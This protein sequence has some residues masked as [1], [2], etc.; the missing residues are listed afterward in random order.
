[1]VDGA[2]KVL[3]DKTAY[4]LGPIYGKIVGI[5]ILDVSGH[6]V[7]DEAEPSG[8]VDA[9]MRVSDYAVHVGGDVS[10]GGVKGILASHSVLVYGSDLRAVGRDVLGRV[11]HS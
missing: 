2:E 11:R 8:F 10:D 4:F 3:P 7:H 9:L 6:K 5:E 1:M